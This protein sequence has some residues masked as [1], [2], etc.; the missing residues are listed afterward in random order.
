MARDIVRQLFRERNQAQHSTINGELI[1]RFRLLPFDPQATLMPSADVRVSGQIL[2]AIPMA[3]A[4]RALLYAQPGQAVTLTRS[5]SGRL[6]VTGF[7]KRAYGHIYHY[8]VVIPE[9]TPANSNTGSVLQSAVVVSGQVSGFLVSVATLAELAT[10]TDGGFGET[11]LQALLLKDA[12][13]T[14]INVVA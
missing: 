3:H 5:P 14:I 9:L 12:D 2:S 4:N 1:S 6:E 11:P 7:S 10:G 8:S 13:G